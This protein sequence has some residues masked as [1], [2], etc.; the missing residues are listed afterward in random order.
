MSG[1]HFISTP[2]KRHVAL[3]Y[4]VILLS[5]L[6]VTLLL[7]PPNIEVEFTF[8][9]TSLG[10]RISIPPKMEV[11][12]ITTSSLI[13]AL[14]K[15]N[16]IPP[17]TADR[18]HPVNSS[19]VKSIFCPENVDTYSLF[20][21]VLLFLFISYYF[22]LLKII[23]GKSLKVESNN[24][25]IKS[26]TANNKLSVTEK[27]HS[28]FKKKDN[29]EVIIY[30]PKDITFD[31]VYISNGA[32]TINIENITTR[33]LELEL[34]AGKLEIDKLITYDNTEIE[35]GAGEVMIKNAK[36]YNLDL[37]VG[38]GKFTLNAS[39]LG[40][41]NIDAGVGELNINL[42]DHKDNYSIYTEAGIGSIRIDGV[43]VKNEANYGTGANKIDIDGGVGSININF[44]E[45]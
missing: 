9:L 31:K 25:Y 19:L 40:S 41:S 33:D 4:I 45:S 22:Q 17:K 34:G 21:V 35:G 26:K 3:T 10:T 8:T 6:F 42:L 14:D 7:T 37:D 13:I 43:N 24:K 28:I 27:R 44:L 30:I 38:V 18:L 29:E 16:S 23:E 20:S 1:T 12:E 5:S 36:L 2:P 11:A 32:G 15:F 39:I